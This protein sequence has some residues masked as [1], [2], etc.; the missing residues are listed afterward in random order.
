MSLFAERQRH[1]RPTKRD[2]VAYLVRNGYVQVKGCWMRGQ[3]EVAQIVP[4]VTGRYLVK[5]GIGA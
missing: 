3:R 5:E 4:L 1:H 2:A